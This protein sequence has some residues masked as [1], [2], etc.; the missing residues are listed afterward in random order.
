M[1]KFLICMVLSLAVFYASAQADGYFKDGRLID[2]MYVNALDGLRL[3]NVP[4]L[5]EKVSAHWLT[6]SP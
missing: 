5:S 3:R 2:T 4:E 1:K 6:L